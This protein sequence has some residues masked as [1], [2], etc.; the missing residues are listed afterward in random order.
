MVSRLPYG[1]AFE[2][3]TREGREG[4]DGPTAEFFFIACAAI[5]A[6]NFR[7]AAVLPQ[8]YS[9]P[10]SAQKLSFLKACNVLNGAQRLK[11]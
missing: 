8:A 7:S 10:A 11:R 6:S 9:S 1:D 3:F 5:V 2:T 4:H